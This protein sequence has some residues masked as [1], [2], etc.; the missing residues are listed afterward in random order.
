MRL[1]LLPGSANPALC[2]AIGALLEV[3]AVR[4][5][6]SRFPDSELHVELLELRLAGRIELDE[7][8]VAVALR[9]VEDAVLSRVVRLRVGAVDLPPHEQGQGLAADDS[10]RTH[11]ARRE[12]RP[13]HPHPRGPA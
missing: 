9:C 8:R 11:R 1:A 12:Q 2:T 4:R 7:E 13:V 10:A 3:T 6:V 5:T